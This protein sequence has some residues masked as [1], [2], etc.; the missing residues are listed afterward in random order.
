VQIA[1]DYEDRTEFGSPINAG[2]RTESWVGELYSPLTNVARAK[3]IGELHRRAPELLAEIV[4]SEEFSRIAD[5]E[6]AGGWRLK[7]SVLFP[8]IKSATPRTITFVRRENGRLVRAELPEDYW[9]EVHGMIAQ[10]VGRDGLDTN[11]LPLRHHMREILAA[12]TREGL[13]ELVNGPTHIDPIL[14]STDFTFV[15]HNTVMARSRTTRIIIDPLLF[16]DCSTYPESYQPLQLR[17]LEAIDAILVTHSHPD[18]FDP[19]SLLQFS[20]RTRIIVPCIEHENLLSVAMEHRLREL[21]FADIK[22]MSW[23]DS[24]TVGDIEIHA[25]PLYGEQPTDGDVFHPDV[26]NVGNTYLLRSPAFSAVFLADSGR[27]LQGDV[28]ALASRT[29]A[30]LGTVDVVFSGYRG[31]HTYPVQLLYSPVSR[32][33]LFV[34]PWLWNSR[35]QLMTSIEEAIDVAERWGAGILVPYADGGAPWHWDAGLGPN[36]CDAATEIPWLDPF[37]R[38]VADAAENRIKMPD[39][40]TI[41]SPVRVLLLHPGESITHTQSAARTVRVARC[42]WPYEEHVVQRAN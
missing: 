26:R 13:T 18:H 36:L 28:K 12:L 34:P 24:T 25:L 7:H 11:A 21:G 33:L 32:Y 6:Q 35:L 2:R 37:P 41:S 40:S 3:G 4:R 16:P 31:W 23:G 38:R 19:A 10:L 5:R 20:P 29:R 30:R 9:A 14:E 39:S 22:S 17:D 27:D 15:G 8:D 1:V 42:M